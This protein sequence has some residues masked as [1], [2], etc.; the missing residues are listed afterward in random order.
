VADRAV[1]VILRANVAQYK[2][3][4]LSAG[5]STEAAM[6]Q[7]SRAASRHQAVWRATSAVMKVGALGIVG[8]LAVATKASADFEAR[9][10]NVKT[11][12]KA[13]SAEMIALRSAAMHAG[14]GYGY[15]ANQVAE[16]EA[17]MV[18]A[19]VSLRDMMGGGLK[20][21]LALAAAGQMNVADATQIAA[22]AMTQFRLKGAALPHVADLLA[23]GADKALGS[24]QELGNGLSQ[25][26]TTAHQSGLSIEQTTGTLT[27][28]AQAGLIGERGGTTFKQMLLRLENP[29]K[30]AA[31]VMHKYG[32]S[33]YD[34]NGQIKTMPQLAGNLQH[35]FEHLTPAQRNAALGTIFGSRAIQGANI[36]M[37]EGV[38][39]MA[40]WIRKVN[41]QGFAAQQAGGK[42]NSLEGDWQKLKAAGENALI[43]IGSG[44]QSPLRHLVQNVTSDVKRLTKDGSLKRWSTEVG[45]DLSTVIRDAGPL[46]KSVGHALELVGNGVKTTVEEFNKLPRGVQTALVTGAGVAAIGHKFGA[47]SL[48]N[49]L[50][51]GGLGGATS[52]AGG[53]AVLAG[54]AGGVVPVYVT[55]AG[56]GAPGKG[57]PGGVPPIVPGGSVAS[58]AGSMLDR[59]LRSNLA[60]ATLEVGALAV[61]NMVPGRAGATATGALVGAGIGGRVAG[62]P[63]AVGGA[64]IGGGIGFAKNYLSDKPTTALDKQLNAPT[65]QAA[66]LAKEYGVLYAAQEK[67][68]KA[69]PK[70]FQEALNVPGPVRSN[71]DKMN[72]L[73]QRMQQITGKS[74]TELRHWATSLASTKSATRDTGLGTKSMALSFQELERNARKAGVPV[75]Q[76]NK[77]VNSLP[78][79]VITQILTPGALKSKGDVQALADQFGLTPKQ[80]QTIMK[81]LGYEDTKQKLSDTIKTGKALNQSS[82]KPHVDVPDAP[83]AI[84]KIKGVAKTGQA[85]GASSW[86]PHITAVDNA[87]GTI[88][89]VKTEIASI[90]GSRNVTI[91][92]TY[93]TYHYT[94]TSTQAAR[95]PSIAKPRVSAP[96]S[97]ANGNLYA[98]ADGGGYD[99]R[100]RYVPRVPQLRRGGGNVLWSEPETGWEA[101][102]SGKPGMRDRNLQILSM[103]AERLGAQVTAKANGGIT[104]YA[105]GG[106]SGLFERKH[107]AH[108]IKAVRGEISKLTGQLKK[109]NDKA[110]QYKASVTQ[111]YSS[112]PFQGTL[113]G[114][115]N[116]VAYETRRLRGTKADL[117]TLHAAGLSGALFR[118]L[119]ASGNSL[120]IHQFAGQS[121]SQ[122][123]AEQKAYATQRSYVGQVAGV[124]TADVT[125]KR[126]SDLTHE[127]KHLTKELHQ[128]RHGGHVGNKVTNVHRA[129]I[130][131][132]AVKSKARAAA[133]R[134]RHL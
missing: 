113:G 14:T 129:I 11:L 27:A 71:A 22:S 25:V 57:V 66:K 82:W 18:K 51:G 37:S 109:A 131:D 102:I 24:V 35:A 19:G 29:S 68:R 64:L 126:I 13:S 30:Q 5:A 130:K 128:L 80:V 120:L 58:R 53:A 4:M 116:Q 75:G 97:S 33:L 20:G 44:A 132:S 114:F 90:P 15:T 28:F 67:I 16:A 96:G 115:N 85:L 112:D 83:R 23:A 91:T 111:A 100:G 55:N 54:R 121:K 79:T 43:S 62:V 133:T 7:A 36:M 106:S 9:M 92:T 103:A 117:K 124:A 10:A 123:A 105:N 32:L 61:H 59:G 81:L 1:E 76:F 122:L 48:L 93:K 125:G 42:L 74:T 101:Y 127:V 63:G 89:R 95:N 78:P 46:A 3:A 107:V 12:A 73:M 108:E 70:K 40:S 87:S 98:F 94:Y 77:M 60:F 38:K 8:G 49:S 47:G 104:R 50:V 6:G 84:Q 21:T 45:N 65:S 134:S 88:A 72:G 118:D 17:E 2:A 52:K 39:G 119:A 99:D 69:D 34:A 86:K 110:A 41:D 56:F 31:D 26:G